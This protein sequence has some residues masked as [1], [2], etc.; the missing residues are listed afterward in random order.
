MAEPG[1]A[2][3]ARLDRNAR[4]TPIRLAFF[5]DSMEVGGSELNAVRTLERLD[6]SR[7]DLRVFHTG[8]KGPLLA[9][10][11]A[12][13]V[14][15]Y[16]VAVRGFLRPGTLVSGL[17]LAREL[18]RQRI[19]ILHSHDIYSNILS[20]PWARLAGVPVIIA[21]RR[22]QAAVPSRGHALANRVASRMATRVLAN[23]ASVA[24]AVTAEDGIPS[25]AVMVVPNF[26]EAAAFDPYP[27]ELRARLLDQFGIPP[28]AVIV[29]I[30]ARLSPVKD[31]ATLLRAAEPLLAER[32]QL[33]V[34]VI[35]DGPLRVQLQAQAA[36][37]PHGERIHFTGHLS[38]EPNPHGLL[39][40]SVLSS[41]TEG[42][43]NAVVEAMAAGKPVVAT[44]VGGT[45]D[46]VREGETGQLVPP[47]NPTELARA[48]ETLLAN[49]E[50]RL[51][52]GAAGRV[53]ARE[54]YHA[55]SVLGQLS[56]WYESLLEGR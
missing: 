7:F 27:A 14:P 48:L 20:I 42:F 26:V 15:M 28:A 41:V 19:Q 53:R 44:A 18:R 23:S 21:S 31:H 35:G 9:R 49:P 13:G 37:M 40:I 33:H 16:H 8:W 38:N 47:G 55:D 6:R 50:L 45:L 2:P 52:Y 43:P 1:T 51:A 4:R 25:G 12:L 54:M 17:R 30:V 46:A 24:R 22:W 36:A 3:G 11:Q 34:L 10:Y 56:E 29:G 39:D 5:V 32:P